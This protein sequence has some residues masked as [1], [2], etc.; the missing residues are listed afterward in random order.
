VM[1]MIVE[2]ATDLAVL[3]A[4]PNP[5]PD[6]NA[7]GADAFV[8]LIAALKFYGLLAGLAGV[9]ISSMVFGLG[10]YF[11]NHHAATFG[12]IGLFAALACAIFIGGGSTLV[13]WAF[14]LG[15]S[16]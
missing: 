4:V 2:Q 16:A 11:G 12:R 15:A 6:G 5:A 8:K 13:D 3:A 10:R 7:P 14:G 1:T 9:I